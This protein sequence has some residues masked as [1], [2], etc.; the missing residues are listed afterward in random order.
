[1][2]TIAPY[3]A[4]AA[5]PELI[6]TDPDVGELPP[7]AY[8]DVGYRFSHDYGVSAYPYIDDAV[9]EHTGRGPIDLTTR[10]E[11]NE[12]IRPGSFSSDWR[13][14]RRALLSGSIKDM[15][16]PDLGSFPVVVSGGDVQILS[17]YRAGVVVSVTWRTTLR[18]PE[19]ALDLDSDRLTL[20]EAALAADE[21]MEN[22]E[23]NFP[24]GFVATSFREL[25][26]Q[27]NS[28]QFLLEL[29]ALRVIAQAQGLI[30]EVHSIAESDPVLG[31]QHARVE[32]MDALVKLYATTEAVKEKLGAV[33]RKTKSLVTNSPISLPAFAA[34][35]GNTLDE[36]MQL[37]VGAIA[38]PIVPEGT[39]LRYFA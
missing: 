32:A 30:S 25:L 16:H 5:L 36:V 12:V 35:V 34:E 39:F 4:I 1:M 22:V 33:T 13:L 26:A 7:V 18:D 17:S 28:A 31:A 9:H 27:I 15:Q 11:F 21:A 8:N 3:D 23:L 24:T 10:L 14:W 37:N 20:D 2:A 29:E 38:A 6:V 19:E